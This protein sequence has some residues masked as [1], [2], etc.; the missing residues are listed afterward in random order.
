[1]LVRRSTQLSYEATEG[2]S[3][4][5]VLN[6]SMDEMMYET[7]LFHKIDSFH[8]IQSLMLSKTSTQ[9]LPTY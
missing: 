7:N 1:M 5:P 9:K 8:N 6:E 2:G 3:N 4:V